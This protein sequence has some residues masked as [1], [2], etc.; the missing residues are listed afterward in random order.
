MRDEIGTGE[1]A[2]V[3]QE[4]QHG[5]ELETI[6]RICSQTCWTVEYEQYVQYDSQLL[7]VTFE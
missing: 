7:L 6:I 1:Y 2:I 4:L 5:D 3:S